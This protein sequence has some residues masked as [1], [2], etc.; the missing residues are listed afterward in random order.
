MKV[1]LAS[2]FNLVHKVE[3]IEKMLE[4]LGYTVICKW[5]RNLDFIPAE[6]KTLKE[7]SFETN[8]EEFFSHPNCER[9]YNRDFKG[10]KDADFLVFIAADYPRK[11]NGANI[12]LGIA[13][14]DKKPCFSVGTL[15][16]SALY[17]PVTRCESISNLFSKIPKTVSPKESQT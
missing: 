11:Y 7:I 6:G 9:A 1:Y 4:E 8:Q 10:V 2:S 5:W 15:E 17:F 16:N 12:E 13:L 3:L 14:G